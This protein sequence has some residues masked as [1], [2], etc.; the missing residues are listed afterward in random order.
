MNI[1]DYLKIEKEM[2]T[3]M[4]TIWE[5]PYFDG[6]TDYKL[7]QKT[8][9]KLLWILK[10]PNG[11]G[12]GNHRVFHQDIRDY[13]RWKSTYGNI[14]CVAYGILDGIKT[15]NEIPPI[16]TKECRIADAIVLD[17]IAIININKSG[18]KSTTPLG[19]MDIEY[20]RTGV[21]DFLF[22]Q[23]EFI[24]PNIIINSHGVYQFFLDQVGN[25]E[26]KKVYGEQYAKNNGRLIIWTSHPNRAP[27]ES[28][29][30]NILNIV[31][32]N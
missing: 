30:N 21:K 27:K 1:D 10:E 11:M 16:N 5:K 31:N 28:Y 17:E 6:I 3:E 24:A 25:N 19:K 13:G 18:G 14:M 15:F 9:I 26:I 12:G 4:A 32:N 29:C 22:K 23:I 20:K 2:D 7:Y 8:P